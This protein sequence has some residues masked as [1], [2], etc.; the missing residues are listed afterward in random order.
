MR[1]AVLSTFPDKKCGLADYTYPLVRE[2]KK[3]KEIEKLVVIGDLESTKADYMV[4]FKSVTLYKKIKEII[5]KELVDILYVGHEYWIYGKTN[6]GFVLVHYKLDI[7]IVTLFSV[8]TSNDPGVSFLE[9]IRA[10]IVERL[11]AS[12]AKKI[13][14]NTGVSKEQLANFPVEKIVEIPLGIS[15]KVKKHEKNGKDK[16]TILFFGIISPHKG[17][18]HLIRSSRYLKN[19]K[20]VIAGRSNFDMKDILALKEEYSRFNEIILDLDW[21]PNE[22]KDKYFSSADLVVLPYTRIGLQSGV[23]YD[24]LSYGVPC[25]V[26][27]G[28]MMG[29][30][31]SEYGLGEVVNPTDPKDIARGINEVLDGYNKYHGNVSKY[32]KIASWEN[33]AKA[34]IKLFKSVFDEMHM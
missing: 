9:H 24:S 28:G 20:I 11:V 22:K 5:D 19:V 23:L 6:L 31:V 10:K 4:D 32:Q 21:I 7:P 13:V 18:E 29:S 30:V 12:K 34:Y 27:K 8:I 15:P 17:V 25:V 3:T 26:G 1:I 14:V 16:K 2:F 33:V